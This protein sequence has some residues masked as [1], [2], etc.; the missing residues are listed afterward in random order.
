MPH[1]LSLSL[2]LFCL[3]FYVSKYQYITHS[4]SMEFNYQVYLLELLPCSIFLVSYKGSYFV[5]SHFEMGIYS[6][7]IYIYI[8]I[9]I[10]IYNPIPSPLVLLRI[11]KCVWCTAIYKMHTNSCT[12]TKN[13]TAN[14]LLSS[15]SVYLYAPL[16]NKKWDR[17]CLIISCINFTIIV[18][19]N[20][21]INN[22]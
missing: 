19:K 15:W 11:G 22:H 4:K 17:D 12:R 2:S 7:Y 3:F 14:L 8:Y 6:K 13:Q 1:S 18:T 9:F 20:F 10:Y 21:L 5:K 16:L